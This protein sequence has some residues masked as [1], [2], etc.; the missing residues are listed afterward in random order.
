MSNITDSE[1]WVHYYNNWS[2]RTG[3]T[4][5]YEEASITN[6]FLRR[7]YVLSGSGTNGTVDDVWIWRPDIDEPQGKYMSWIQDY[8]SDSFYSMGKNE[9][10]VYY[11]NSP[12]GMTCRGMCLTKDNMSI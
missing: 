5:V 2:P 6:S 1:K 8:S 12:T 9:S 7:V 3:H 11:N 4:A 10:L